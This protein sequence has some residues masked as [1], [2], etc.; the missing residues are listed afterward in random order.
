M[1]SRAYRFAA[2]LGCAALFVAGGCAAGRP[3]PS[4][5]VASDTREGHSDA[6]LA[7]LLP[8]DEPGCSAAVGVEGRVVWAGA[9]GTADLASG[10]ALNTDSVFDI[11]SVSKQFTATAVLLL[12]Q[13]GKLALTDS[14]ATHL[15]GLPAWARRVTV[16]DLMRHTSGIPDYTALLLAAGHTLE[17]RTTQRQAVKAIGT[18]PKSRFGPVGE[19][20]Y[21]NSNYVLLA[22]IVEAAS[23]RALPAF[24]A[25]RVFQPLDLPMAMDPAVRGGRTAVAYTTGSSGEWVA[26]RS[27]WTQVGD[28]SV[29]GT[30]S[31]LVRWADNYR[32]GK[33]GGS[34]LLRA[35]VDGA[36]PAGPDGARYGAG[37]I[38]Q[39]DGTLVHE[40]GWAGYTTMFGVTAD[41]RTAIAVSCNTDRKDIA[42]VAGGLL[43]IWA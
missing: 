17:E 11:A 28:G 37:L 6:L 12:A 38:V 43:G 27:G 16:G 2:A 10:T 7:R 22:E 9:R 31:A 34:A 33:V 40:G 30:P 26:V 36:V 29:Q 19:F 13:D 32:T 15:T 5:G 21:S 25:A 35:Q 8:R 18:A 39:S 23:G 24:L 42:G 20:A 3:E 41:R 4:P 1:A 14:V